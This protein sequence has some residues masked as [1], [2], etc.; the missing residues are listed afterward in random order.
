MSRCPIFDVFPSRSL[1]P[2]YCCFGTSPSK[3]A[4]SR[5]RRRVARLGANVSIANAVTR[6][7]PG[8]VCAWRTKSPSLA[9]RFIFPSSSAIRAVRPSNCFRYSRRSS[10]TSSGRAM[11]PSSMASAFR[12]RWAGP[13][14]ATRPCSAKRTRKA[15]ISWMRCPTPIPCHDAQPPTYSVSTGQRLNLT[16]P[17]CVSSHSSARSAPRQLETRPFASVP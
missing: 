3:A 17:A 15:L 8:M 4:R 14:V 2:V 5:P 10:R 16:P 12:L 13:R 7:T 1:L 11:S 6:S 9:A